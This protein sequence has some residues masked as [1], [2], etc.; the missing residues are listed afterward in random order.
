MR[1][2]IRHKAVSLQYQAPYPRS[3][4]LCSLP[5]A[6]ARLCL[7]QVRELQAAV[8]G[9]RSQVEALAAASQQK[10][11]EHA[12]A[13]EGLQAVSSGRALAGHGA[14]GLLTCSVHDAYAATDCRVHMAWGACQLSRM[15]AHAPPNK[16][17][18]S[19]PA[20]QA[21]AEQRCESAAKDAALTA[22]QVRLATARGQ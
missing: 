16:H 8:R 14:K 10:E 20:L 11:A 4:K 12:A 18:R 22:L 17:A 13:L 1:L 21:A 7:P 15:A 6:A 19:R 5:A 3:R 2:T 9:E